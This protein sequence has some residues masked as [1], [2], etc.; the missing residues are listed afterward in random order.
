VRPGVAPSNTAPF[1]S[2]L[3]SLSVKLRVKIEISGAKSKKHKGNRGFFGL[4]TPHQLIKEKTKEILV[5]L[6]FRRVWLVA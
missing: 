4:A 6:Y 2:P 5:R 1:D 3:N